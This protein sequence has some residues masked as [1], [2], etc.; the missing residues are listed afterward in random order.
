LR[1]VLRAMRTLN[2]S[3]RQDMKSWLCLSA[4]AAVVGWAL[5]AAPAAAVEP[6]GAKVFEMRTYIANPGKLEALHARFRDHTCQLFKKHG[7]EVVGF[8]TPVEGD[9]AKNTL[10][11][12]VAFPSVEAQKK[13]WQDF[14]KDPEWIAAKAASEKN[15]VLVKQVISKNLK[16][17]DYSPIR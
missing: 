12:L 5:A 1:V 14:R 9:E 17:T 15:G 10:V 6:A 13:A 2:D 4:L 16:G 8:W 11:Y 3:R 7:V